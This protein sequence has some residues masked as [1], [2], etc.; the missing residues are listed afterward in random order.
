[1]PARCHRAASSRSRS[2]P[3]PG[4]G[5]TSNVPPSSS[6]CSRMPGKAEVALGPDLA[7]RRSP[8]RHPTPSPGASPQ[9]RRPGPG[10]RVPLPWRVLFDSSSWRA[11]KRAIFV[12][13]RR[14]AE[15]VVDP[16]VDLRAAPAHVVVHR[17]ADRRP[18][19]TMPSSSGAAARPRSTRMSRS[20]SVSADRSSSYSALPVGLGPEALEPE[21]C[22]G[23]HL[24]RAVVQVAADPAQVA[25]AERGRSLR[26]AA[27]RSRSCSFW[28][29]Q[30]RTARSPGVRS[31][32]C[33]RTIVS[34]PCRTIPYSSRYARATAPATTGPRAQLCPGDLL[35]DLRRQLVELGHGD[36]AVG[37]R[38]RAPA[39]TSRAGGRSGRAR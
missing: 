23:Q 26:C 14:L 29:E 24:A 15:A 27:H 36:D 30:R 38:A 18:R 25:L 3:P 32:C 13:R 4:A 1:M 10:S 31:A 37:C 17:A 35:I 9:L 11:R 34:L 6:A 28:F 19:S 7:R 16:D 5:A 2:A 12:G 33:W 22:Q 21:H 8:G 20:A 39:G